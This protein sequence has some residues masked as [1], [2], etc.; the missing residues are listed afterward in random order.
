MLG[1]EVVAPS[2]HPFLEFGVPQSREHGPPVQARFATTQRKQYADIASAL[3][4]IRRLDEEAC[5]M[6]SRVEGRFYVSILSCCLHV[7]D[8]YGG[9]IKR[10]IAL[11]HY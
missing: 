4:F 9:F 2:I 6:G 3:S 8:V 10:E 5:S 11:R 7:Q 1:I